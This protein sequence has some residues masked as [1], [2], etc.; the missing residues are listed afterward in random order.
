MV[1][2]IFD[3]FRFGWKFTPFTKET[4]IFPSTKILDILLQDK[5]NS[6]IMSLDRR[7]MPPNFSVSYKLQDVAGYDSLFLKSYI[8]LVSSWDKNRADFALSS[9]HRI[10]TPGN[11]ES[12]LADLLGVKYFLSF[13]PQNNEKIEFVSQEGQT[14]LYK[15][16]EVFPRAFLTEEV[17]KV[18]NV[19]QELKE[20]FELGDKLRFLAVTSENINLD[21]RPLI[22]SERV[23]VIIYE[24]NY[25]KIEA[26]TDA[27]RLMVLTD[28]YYPS[29]KAFI[30]G[31]E[32]KIFRVDFAFRGI[33]VP[34]GQHQIEFKTNWL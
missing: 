10:V 6:R 30:D 4:W 19:Q 12:F 27:S 25:I 2:I 32:T 23:N 34:E 21:S 26:N 7:L 8:Q 22:S 13:G 15:N 9:Y 33:I 11:F 14:Y 24:E 18:E 17:V 1:F 3:L 16:P 31:K 29:W 20:I 5:Q 28:V